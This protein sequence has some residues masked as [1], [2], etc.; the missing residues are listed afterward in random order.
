MAALEGCWPVVSSKQDQDLFG[1]TDGNYPTAIRHSLASGPDLSELASK[2]WIIKSVV[3]WFAICAYVV[4]NPD[5]R[6][7]EYN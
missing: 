7:V 4:H 1:S 2:H 6:G 3:F 5:L